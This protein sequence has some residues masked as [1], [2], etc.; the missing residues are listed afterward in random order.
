MNMLLLECDPPEVGQSCLIG[1][2]LVLHIEFV[3][4]F[5]RRPLFPT[6]R[7]VSC[8]R[9]RLWL[10]TARAKIFH[11][12][13]RWSRD[14]IKATPTSVTE[15]QC[16]RTIQW[17]VHPNLFKRFLVNLG[18]T[19]LP[20]F[21]GRIRSCSFFFGNKQLEPVLVPNLSSLNLRRQLWSA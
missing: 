12:A 14:N 19:R 11:G 1:H 9:S 6:P 13:A 18:C 8:S 2:G 20:S 17:R 3:S 10:T 21:A 7:Y 16:V 4:C 5:G 15:F